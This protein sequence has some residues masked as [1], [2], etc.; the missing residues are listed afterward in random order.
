[1]KSSLVSVLS[2]ALCVQSSLQADDSPAAKACAALEQ[3]YP[4]LTAKG[5]DSRYIKANT[6]KQCPSP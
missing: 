6:G 1:M 5:L 2:L 4:K 3:K